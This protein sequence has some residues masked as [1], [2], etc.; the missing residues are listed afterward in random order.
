MSYL[1]DAIIKKSIPDTPPSFA[2]ATPGKRAGENAIDPI[3]APGLAGAAQRR[4]NIMAED[5]RILDADQ[6][7]R[8]RYRDQY[9]EFGDSARLLGGLAQTLGNP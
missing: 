4:A 3:P 5:Q 6:A 9:G 1:A 7:N 8:R 2:Q